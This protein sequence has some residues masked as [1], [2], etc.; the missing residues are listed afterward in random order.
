MRHIK[1]QM[2]Y[3][4]Y[5]SYN[6]KHMPQNHLEVSCQ[7][8]FCDITL[9][10]HSSHGERHNFVFFTNITSKRLGTQN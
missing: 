4:K 2:V 7:I 9:G 10:V 5:E 3:F 6:T 8:I 1:Q